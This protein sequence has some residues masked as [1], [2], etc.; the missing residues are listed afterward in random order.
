VRSA[1][2]GIALLLLITS[3]LSAQNLSG[4]WEG[5]IGITKTD[6]LTVGLQIDYQGDTLYAELDSP[7]QY[8]TGQPVSGLTFADSA[9]AFRVPDFGLN[10][11]GTLSADGQ[12]FT[13]TCTQYGRKF[14]CTLSQGATRKLFPRPQ[15]PTPP[16]PYRTEEVNFRDR[17]GKKNLI[18]G[19]L[20]LPKDQPKGLV[21]F[22][23]GSGWQDRDENIF[24][25][26][27]FAVIADTLTKAGFAT[28]RYDDFPAAIFRKSTTYDFADG[29]R[30]ILDS[31][32]QRTDL[33]GLKVTLLGHSE[34][35]LVASIV[36]ADD[37]RIA[38]TIHL[39]GVAQ[40][41]EE[42]LLYQSEAILRVSG[43]MTEPE[44]ENSVAINQ[45]I[46]E[47]IKK[48]KS[49]DDAM[50]RVGKLWDELSAQLSDEEKAK[51]NMT[52]GNKFTAIQTFSSPWFYTLFQIDPAKYLKKIKT[53]VLAISGEMDLQVNAIATGNNLTKYLKKKELL[54]FINAKGLNHLLQ[55]CTTCS[56]DEYEHIETTI[57]PE[58]L[59]IIV[60]WLKFHNP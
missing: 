52:P 39:G 6:S 40:P 36:A 29:V 14:D 42:I 8:F 50:K 21:I 31:L 4:Y 19:T 2:W 57:A 27:P 18:F 12:R 20:T 49:T 13:G 23:S 45:R 55:P 41:F 26:K 28:Y 24:A 47:V 58:V 30:L 17:D 10:Y 7:D 56:P 3:S 32:M 46:Y 1:V 11:E 44:I 35:S 43:E 53:P 34:G 5:K 15:T 59:D 54:S 22:I 38:S 16:Y 33:Q 51:Y 60:T 48:S 37:K 9:I 25:H